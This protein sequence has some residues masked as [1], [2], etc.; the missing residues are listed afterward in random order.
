M[1]YDKG[2]LLNIYD[3]IKDKRENQKE[4]IKQVQ[5]LDNEI[6]IDILEYRIAS[7]K[8]ILDYIHSN[9]MKVAS[10]L[11]QFD[12]LITHCCNKLNGNID[13]IEIE[14]EGKNEK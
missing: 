5:E 14:L 6:K 8:R 13:G 2:H 12:T 3:A 4:Y 1:E 11:K 7:V 9:Q 10:D